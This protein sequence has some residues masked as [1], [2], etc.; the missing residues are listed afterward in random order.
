MPPTNKPQTRQLKCNDPRVVRTFNQYYFEFLRKHKL[1]KRAFRLEADAIY[2]LPWDLQQQAEQLDTLKMQGILHADK[3]CRKLRMGGVPYSKRYKQLNSAIGFWNK[4]LRRK[5]GNRVKSK[6]LQRLIKKAVIPTPLCTIN[7]YTLE[8]VKAARWQN[9][10]DYND[11]V[12]KADVARTTWLKELAE[13]R[14]EEDLK[15]RPTSKKKK[16]ATCEV[17]E[18]HDEK[19]PLKKATADQ[20]RQLCDIERIRSSARRVKAA[21]GINR[22]SCITMVEAPNEDGVTEQY[23]DPEGIVRG[24]IW[25]NKRRFRQTEGTPFMQEPLRTSVGYL[26]IGPGA[27]DI[28]N[29]TFQCP[30]NTPHAA[31]LIQGLKRIDGTHEKPIHAG[32]PT[33]E[34]CQGWKRAKEKTSAGPLTL[35]FGHCKAGALDPRIIKFEAAMASIPMKSGY[36]YKLWRKGTDVEL[37]RKANSFHVSKLRTIV[38]FEA[39]FDFT[40]KAVG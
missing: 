32:M 4:M 28:I 34:Y 27:Q 3:N 30:A 38:L 17:D 40:N 25:E 9:F 16:R 7:Q 39:D 8:Q 19:A 29:G 11:F 2:P 14:A 33:E 37:L 35:H 22:L 6:H 36:A 20:L 18:D 26:G 12:S 15:K 10:K 1:H 13:A 23:T 21:L 24:C 5:Q 31:R